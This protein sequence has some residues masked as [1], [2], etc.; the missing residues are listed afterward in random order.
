M[1]FACMKPLL[2]FSLIALASC[3]SK[4]SFESAVKKYVRDSVVVKF[5]DP[6][7]TNTFR[8]TNRIANTNINSTKKTWTFMQR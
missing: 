4:P 6:L 1:K 2:L 8:W 7:L 5:D 3:N